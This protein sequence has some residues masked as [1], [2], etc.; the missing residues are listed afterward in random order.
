MPRPALH[1]RSLLAALAGGLLAAAT[2]CSGDSTGLGN[3]PPETPEALYRVVNGS[4]YALTVVRDGNV[5]ARDV[6]SGEFTALLGLPATGPVTVQLRRAGGA[7]DLPVTFTARAGVLHTIAATAGS[8]LPVVARVLGEAGGD[9]V[10]ARGKLRFV[11]LAAG[12]PAV[13]LWYVAPGGD[14][15]RA[16]PAPLPLG[17]ETAYVENIP[18]SWRVW[19]TPAGQSA[20][21][22]AESNA[23]LVGSGVV[24]T[25]A[26]LP[27]SEGVTLRVFDDR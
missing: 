18:G 11:N 15:T 1:R 13:D 3:G 25:V 9:A 10:A 12:A 14:A 27:T 20:P 21:V 5:V 19:A 23:V 8:G 26:L 2:A 7:E 17:A 6:P 16:T 4:P 24:R 22:L